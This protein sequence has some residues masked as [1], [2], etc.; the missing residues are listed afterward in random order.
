[1]DAEEDD[2]LKLQQSAPKLL[3]DL[4]ILLP[5]ILRHQGHGSTPGAVR[6]HVKEADIKKLIFAKVRS[7]SIWSDVYARLHVPSSNSYK[8]THSFSTLT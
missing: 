8:K 2:D 5:R 4:T 1:M 3:S 6:R 7:R